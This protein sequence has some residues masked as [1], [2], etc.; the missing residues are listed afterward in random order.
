MNAQEREENKQAVSNVITEKA[1][2][3]SYNRFRELQ[4]IY[5]QAFNYSTQRQEVF[6]RCQTS[7]LPFECRIDR[8]SFELLLLQA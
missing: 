4:K 1:H 5:S 8:I 3:E 7:Y 6:V 2:I